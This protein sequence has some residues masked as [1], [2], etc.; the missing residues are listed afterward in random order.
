MVL[1]YD[2]DAIPIEAGESVD[3]L[4]VIDDEGSSN[5]DEDD[6]AV[7]ANADDCIEEAEDEG[8]EPDENVTITKSG[9]VSRPGPDFAKEQAA[10]MMGLSVLTPELSY[11]DTLSAAEQNYYAVLHEASDEEFG[12]GEIACD[13]ANIGGGFELR[14][15]RAT[16]EVCTTSLCG[17]RK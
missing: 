16:W 5:G 13:E 10:E 7:D 12:L 4:D 17:N 15:G 6:V 2:L 9:R 3:V 8:A 11:F 1:A 14:E